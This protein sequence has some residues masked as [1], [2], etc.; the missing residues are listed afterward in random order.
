[1]GIVIFWIMTVALSAG[2]GHA[3]N[4]TGEG[5]ILGLVLGP[6]G[7]I[8]IALLPGWSPPSPAPGQSWPAP[9]KWQRQPPPNLK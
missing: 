3:K 4:R 7:V 2:I 8:V 5:V 6:I 1:M 9:S